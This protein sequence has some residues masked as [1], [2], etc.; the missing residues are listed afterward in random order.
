MGTKKAFAVVTALSLLSFYSVAET[1]T[2]TADNLDDAEAVIAAQ[3][4]KAGESYTITEATMNN[5]VH[6]TAE[7]HK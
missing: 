4:K 1:V 6:M 3:A 2:A 5:E 7:L